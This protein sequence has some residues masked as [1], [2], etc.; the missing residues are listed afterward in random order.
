MISAAQYIETI[1][2]FLRHGDLVTVAK[3]MN[4]HGVS[5]QEVVQIVTQYRRRQRTRY[6]IGALASLAASG[7]FFWVTFLLLQ[8]TDRFSPPLTGVGCGFALIG[9]GCVYRVIVPR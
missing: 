2:L 6:L 3:M 4:D 7:I 5:Y 9:V 1:R 8:S